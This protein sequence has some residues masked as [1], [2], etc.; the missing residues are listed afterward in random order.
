MRDYSAAG[1]EMEEGRLYTEGKWKGREGKGADDAAW[2]EGLF[3]CSR[4]EGG[5]GGD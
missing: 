2:S 3:V 5:G 4:G 1:G